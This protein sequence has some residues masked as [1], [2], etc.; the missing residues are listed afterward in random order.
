MVFNKVNYAHDFLYLEGEGGE[1]GEAEEEE[2]VGGRGKRKEGG[3]KEKSRRKGGRKRLRLTCP[4]L[5]R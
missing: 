3:K 4:K 2:G 5:S 1:K